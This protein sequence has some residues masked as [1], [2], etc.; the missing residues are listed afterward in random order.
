MFEVEIKLQCF[1]KIGLTKKLLDIRAIKISVEKNHDIYYNHPNR[2]FLSTDESLRIR[3]VKDAIELTYKGKKIDPNSK[4]RQELT[5]LVSSMEIAEIL[6]KLNFDIGGEVIKN[7]EIWNFDDIVIT[8]DEVQDL[9]NYFELE[10]GSVNKNEIKYL[11]NKLHD[12]INKL[13][14]DPQKQIKESYLEL[15]RRKSSIAFNK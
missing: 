12:L 9:G 4:T 6:D 5:V 3:S 1:D 2:D 14:Y 7:R 13:G 15:I 11:V 10:I 8:L